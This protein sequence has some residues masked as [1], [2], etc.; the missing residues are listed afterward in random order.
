MNEFHTHHANVTVVERL[1]NSLDNNIKRILVILQNSQSASSADQYIQSNMTYH[2]F[3]DISNW[4][5]YIV[6]FEYLAI[7]IGFRTN[8]TYTSTI[9]PM[10]EELHELWS[11]TRIGRFESALNSFIRV[12]AV[13]Y[14]HIIGRYKYTILHTH[15]HYSYR[16]IWI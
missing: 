7:T 12:L 2:I 8:H 15:V 16:W 14:I 5:F 10:N 4:L 13:N 9:I 6:N 11:K 1:Q 3:A